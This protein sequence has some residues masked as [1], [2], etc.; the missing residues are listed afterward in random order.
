MSP[1]LFDSV[2]Y[3]TKSSL[4]QFRLSKSCVPGACIRKG[5]RTTHVFAS[6]TLPKIPKPSWILGMIEC[7]LLTE[8]PK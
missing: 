2:L 3:V 4:K 1:S 8:F 5:I 6:V 7:S